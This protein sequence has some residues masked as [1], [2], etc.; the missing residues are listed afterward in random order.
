[1]CRGFESADF[2]VLWV[3]RE[4]IQKKLPANLAPNIRI[5]TWL[6][7]TRALLQ[8]PNV[9]VFVSHCGVNSVYESIYA[10]TPIVGIPMFAAQNDMG[11]RVQDAGVGVLLNKSTFSSESLQRA[12]LAVMND[13]NYTRNTQK[14]KA[15][16]KEAGGAER[17]A[18]IIEREAGIARK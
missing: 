11:I 14:I 1:M 12:I 17:A 7:S 2:R 3:M 9:K 16:F 18:D 4:S 6:S 15:S 8:H 13:P 10:G 5:E